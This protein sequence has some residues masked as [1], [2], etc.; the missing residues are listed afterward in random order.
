[1]KLLCNNK[2]FE[3]EDKY[4]DYS[5][6][7]KTMRTTNVG[8]EQDED[9]YILDIDP[10]QME[11][12]LKFL[13]GVKFNTETLTEHT[14]LYM[15]HSNPYNY[16]SDYWKIKLIDN[17]IR[18]RFYELKLYEKDPYYGLIKHHSWRNKKNNLVLPKGAYIAGGY[19]LY[20]AYCTDSYKDIDIFFTEETALY[21]FLSKYKKEDEYINV[22]VKPNTISFHTQVID[23][24]KTKWVDIQCILR[25]YKSPSEIVHGF[26]VDCVGVLYDTHTGNI[27]MT[28]RATYACSEK[29]NWFDPTRASPSYAYRLGKYM[30]RGLN[31]ELPLFNPSDINMDAVKSIKTSMINIIMEQYF[32][33]VEIDQYGD[34]DQSY[35]ELINFLRRSRI[36]YPLQRNPDSEELQNALYHLSLGSLIKVASNNYGNNKK[37]IKN[38]LPQDHASIL[39]LISQFKCITHMWEQSDYDYKKA[40]D[41]KYTY[42]QLDD[43]LKMKFEWKEQNPMEQVSST[44]YPTPIQDLKEWYKTSSLIKS[45][46]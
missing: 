17:W 32:P 4:A 3:I 12:Y 34:S 37:V 7:L 18:D 22:V 15:G 21:E 45:D 40:K 10:A 29:V 31:I 42:T 25:L 16:P 11:E 39:I 27:Y 35:I 13:R 19:A 8:V 43:V 44:F 30:L 2:E 24:N 26:D 46:T 33:E 6:L 5:P 9:R 28:E 14:F 1:M 41:W 38:A 23:D 36:E 20:L